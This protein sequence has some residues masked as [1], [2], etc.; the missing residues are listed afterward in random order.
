MN[1]C[2]PAGGG[3]IATFGTVPENQGLP[4]QPSASEFNTVTP[5]TAW[6]AQFDEFPMDP[7]DA[8]PSGAEDEEILEE[9]ED[10]RSNLSGHVVIVGEE[11]QQEITVTGQDG[12][13]HRVHI[14]VEEEEEG[15]FLEP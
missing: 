6:G 13:R 8:Y 5:G 3:R 1:E 15:S 4:S 9:D 2:S 11:G 12:L 14:H 10:G 7:M